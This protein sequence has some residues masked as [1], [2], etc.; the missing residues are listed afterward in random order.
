MIFHVNT[1]YS[2]LKVK[3]LY[4]I[5]HVWFALTE[6][7]KWTQANFP[8]WK[9][10]IFFHFCY[11]KDGFIFH[12]SMSYC[13]YPI[14]IVSSTIKHVLFLSSSKGHCDEPCISLAHDHFPVNI[15]HNTS[16][17]VIFLQLPHKVIIWSALTIAWISLFKISFIRKNLKPACSD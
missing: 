4:Q 3:K 8:L 15:Y 1:F 11:S 13:Q 17:R 12:L 2:V 16:E 9:V 7:L 10:S 5:P 14:F 6:V